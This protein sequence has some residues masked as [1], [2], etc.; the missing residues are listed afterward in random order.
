MLVTLE[1]LKTY[2]VTT[3]DQLPRHSID[4]QINILDDSTVTSVMLMLKPHQLTG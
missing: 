1:S 3:R 2:L 4:F